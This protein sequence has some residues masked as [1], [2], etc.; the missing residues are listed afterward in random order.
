MRQMARQQQQLLP[1][2]QRQNLPG[3][4]VA[5]LIFKP[6]SCSA[7]RRAAKSW[8]LSF[9]MVGKRLVGPPSKGQEE[10][11]K[12]KGLVES[13]VDDRFASVNNQAACWRPWLCLLYSYMCPSARALELPSR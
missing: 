4:A 11:E 12:R 5:G 1:S 3:L 9:V 7:C 2:S 10:E 6:S 13:R 8:M